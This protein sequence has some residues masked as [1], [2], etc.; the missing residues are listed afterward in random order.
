MN[1]IENEIIEYYLKGRSINYITKFIC[2]RYCA[3][4]IF[5]IYGMFLNCSSFELRKEYPKIVH[6][7]VEKTILEYKRKQG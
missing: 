3:N 6:N 2:K 1:S 7:L 4:N 5:M